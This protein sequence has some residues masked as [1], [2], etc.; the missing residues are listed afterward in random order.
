MVIFFFEFF[1]RMA[2]GAV[3]SERINKR[4]NESDIF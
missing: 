1:L 3:Y 2:H 4:K